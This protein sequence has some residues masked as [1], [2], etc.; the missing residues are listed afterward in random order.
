MA[1]A[2]TESYLEVS[3]AFAFN[4]PI[5]FKIHWCVGQ[6][7]LKSELARVF[8]NEVLLHRHLLCLS[9]VRKAR[10]GK[11]PCTVEIWL[12]LGGGGVTALHSEGCS[13]GWMS[14]EQFA[15]SAGGNL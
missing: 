8:P 3:V 11:G 13:C 1:F 2:L 14:S 6:V 9:P 7:V 15:P 5:L 4:S 12:K 10:Q